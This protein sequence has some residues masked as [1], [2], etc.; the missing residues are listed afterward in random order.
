MPHAHFSFFRRCIVSMMILCN[1]V[2][3]SG[4]SA[5]GATSPAPSLPAMLTLIAG[6]TGGG[7]YVQDGSGTAARF[8]HAAAI[9]TDKEGNHYVANNVADR[10]EVPG[11]ASI[12]KVTPAGG[13]STL[14][15]RDGTGNAFAFSN[16]VGIVV[17]QSNH[18]VVS[19]SR[20][21]YR[22][23]A[24]GVVSKIA[25]LAPAFLDATHTQVLGTMQP[26][27]LAIDALGNIYAASSATSPFIHSSPYFS[28]RKIT[29]GGMISDVS[30]DMVGTLAGFTAEA[31]GK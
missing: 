22:I 27:P 2:A 21:I 3:C 17:D 26:G 28:I 31:T 6:N 5:D 13:V 4:G 14:T 9:A 8:T 12:R 11:G 15:I 19:E 24:A 29:P 23:S 20:G 25:E 16:I 18:V 7:S 10:D 30:A 1:L